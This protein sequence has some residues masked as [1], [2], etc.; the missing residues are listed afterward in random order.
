M[1]STSKQATAA[2]SQS[3]HA[4]RRRRSSLSLATDG[5]S[6]SSPACAPASAPPPTRWSSPPRR[7]PMPTPPSFGCGTAA[8]SSPPRTRSCRFPADQPQTQSRTP[9]G[10]HG[11]S[12][13]RS[14]RR[15][16]RRWP[17]PAPP[18]CSRR[19]AAA[20]TARWLWWMKT[21]AARTRS[22]AGTCASRSTRFPVARTR[23]SAWRRAPATSGHRMNRTAPVATSPA[24][25]CRRHPPRPRERT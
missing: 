8:C 21:D 13:P 2:S 19:A 12:R 15:A 20:T 1:A 11:Q 9:S 3:H 16:K 25:R 18:P 6:G 23:P 17:S 14:V 7:Q 22:C 5:A 10:R 4:T 24:K